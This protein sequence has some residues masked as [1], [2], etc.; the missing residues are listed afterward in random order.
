MSPFSFC[1]FG[2][3]HFLPFCDCISL[4]S[5]CIPAFYVLPLPVF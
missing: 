2:L 3:W 1:F 5:F 4:D